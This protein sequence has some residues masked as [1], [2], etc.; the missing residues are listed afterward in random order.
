[1][2]LSFNEK[3]K[4][5]QIDDDVYFLILDKQ[6]EILKKYRTNITIFRIVDILLT[7]YIDK[8]EELFHIKGG[9]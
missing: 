3:T 9:L 6:R 1:M 4:T 5:V 2:S 8:I 7:N